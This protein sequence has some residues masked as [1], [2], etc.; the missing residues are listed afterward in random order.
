MP[1]FYPGETIPI[2]TYATL[3]TA[4]SVAAGTR[5]RVSDLGIS[6]GMVLVTDGTRWLPDGLQLI[7]RITTDQTVTASSTNEVVVATVTIPANLLGVNGGLRFESWWTSTNSANVKTVR[8]RLGG[9][10]GTQISSNAWTTSATGFFST[11]V[12][13]R[14]SASSQV[15]GIAG[16]RSSDTLLTMNAQTTTAIDTTAALDLVLTGQKATGSETLTLNAADIWVL[17]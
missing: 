1:L 13:N 7:A 3:P 11:R 14:N 16:N 8:A 15:M 17:A 2:C 9:G 6:P 4:S 5:R 10:S 12:F